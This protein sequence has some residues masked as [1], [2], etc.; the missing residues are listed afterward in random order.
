MKRFLLATAL[1]FAFAAPAAADV[2]DDDPLH[3]CYSTGCSAF[4]GV[5]IG[6]TGGGFT[7]FGVSSSPAPQTG[8]LFF[9]LLTPSNEK[10]TVFPTLTGTLNGN[11]IIGIGAGLSEG[12]FGAAGNLGNILK[13]ALG[14]TF[15]PPNP[16]AAF[17]GA[18]LLEDPLFTDYDVELFKVGAFT[19]GPDAGQTPNMNNSFSFAGGKFGLFDGIGPGSIITA[20]LV[21]TGFDKKGNPFIDVVSTAQSSALLVTPTSV[22]SVPEPSTWLLGLTGF[23]FVAAMGF[24]KSRKN[25]LAVLS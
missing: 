23:G 12:T 5:T 3:L 21:E 22:G 25:R 1:A 14:N 8:T 18:T 24:R 2:A 4:G 15:T 19:T 13:L 11:P 6:G 17:A 7:G 16:F 20:F 10:E 9:A